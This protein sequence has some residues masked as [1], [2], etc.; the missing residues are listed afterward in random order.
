MTLYNSQLKD[1]ALALSSEELEKINNYHTPIQKLE[2]VCPKCKDVKLEYD[3]GADIKN[4]KYYCGGCGTLKPT[5]NATQITILKM[6][7][8][9]Q[10]ELVRFWETLEEVE[11]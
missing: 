1:I 7:Y 11:K 3:S 2:S 6:F 8:E 4:K 5:T 9:V 10:V